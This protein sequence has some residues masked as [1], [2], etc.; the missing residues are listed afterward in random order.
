MQQP[1]DAPC[2][3]SRPTVVAADRLGCSCIRPIALIWMSALLKTLSEQLARLSDAA[4]RREDCSRPALLSGAPI[5]TS[6]VFI[7]LS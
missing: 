7:E 6:D 3:P 2:C 5:S 4:T 1:L